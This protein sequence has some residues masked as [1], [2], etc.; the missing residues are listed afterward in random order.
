MNHTT[1]DEGKLF[2][3]LIAESS[4]FMACLV[5]NKQ[6]AAAD[7]TKSTVAYR[8]GTL[9]GPVINMLHDV[10]M[11]ATFRHTNKDNCHAMH[12]NHTGVLVFATPSLDIGH[13]ST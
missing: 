3:L 11:L 1:D 7:G 13:S 12:D 2:G 8:V 9:Y 6:H 5:A 10:W 4:R